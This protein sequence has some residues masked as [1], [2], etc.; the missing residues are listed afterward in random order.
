LLS[1]SGLDNRAAEAMASTPLSPF[2][3]ELEAATEPSL[4]ALRATLPLAR[5]QASDAAGTTPWTRGPTGALVGR[6]LGGKYE[7]TRPLGAGGMGEVYRAAHRTLGIDVAVKVMR[8]ALTASADYTRRFRREALAVSLI[9]HRNVV[10]IIDYGEQDGLLFLVMEHLA[11]ETMAAW[12]DHT[13]APPSYADIA[14]VLGQVLE[15]LDAA[16][17]AGIVHRD[18]KPDNVFLTVESDGRRIAKVVDFGLAHVDDARD[19]GP[20]LT[21]ADTVSG[22]PEYM[23]PE[24]CRSLAVGPS[25]DIYAIGCILTE[26]LQLAPPFE[27]QMIEVLAKQ[28]FVAPTPLRRPD[29]SPDVPPLLERLRLDLLAKDPSQRPQSAREARARL[30]EALD[31]ERNAT[32]FPGRSGLADFDSRSSRHITQVSADHRPPRA[33]PS[34][35]AAPITLVRFEAREGGAGATCALGLAAQGFQI[36]ERSVRD[37]LPEGTRVV[38]LDVGDDLPRGLAW[39]AKEKPGATV[40]CLAEVT[41]A[42]L[43]QLIAAGIT[44]IVAY[45]VTSDVL[46]RKLRRAA[47]RAG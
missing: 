23:S 44:E 8:S 21:Q 16:H 12:I 17:N 9:H 31:L 25:T 11:G 13:P 29:G 27:G 38:V 34:P 5:A 24:Q 33:A 6:I 22:T 4:P 39:L 32:A 40:V 36:T 37:A 41:A 19:D 14:D 15:A 43:T 28:M 30:L 7:L 26:L 35:E 20:P 3:R 45:P 42:R 18:L 1:A 10:K 46:A 47:R 2:R